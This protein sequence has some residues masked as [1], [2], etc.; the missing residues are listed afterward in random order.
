MEPMKK[1]KIVGPELHAG[2]FA[3]LPMLG[4]VNQR[5]LT[6]LKNASKAERPDPDFANANVGA[7]FLKFAPFFTMYSY[8]CKAQKKSS[9]ALR[10]LKKK[11]DRFVQFQNQC[12]KIPETNGLD[13]AVSSKEVEGFNGM[14]RRGGCDH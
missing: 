4:S 6:E 7:V 14:V 8:F 12:R 10:E 11:S 13:L 9:Q 3:N 1:K 5:L 2:L